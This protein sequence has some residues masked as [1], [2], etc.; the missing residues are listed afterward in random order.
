MFSCVSCSSRVSILFNE[1]FSLEICS[2]LCPQE[3]TVWLSG[4]CVLGVLMG[5]A[6]K[7]REETG[8]WGGKRE[9]LVPEWANETPRRR[10]QMA[11][12]L[13]THSFILN[14]IWGTWEPTCLELHR[15]TELT[16]QLPLDLRLKL[17]LLRSL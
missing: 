6:C 13:E 4:L 2:K 15:F 10:W 12:W 1:V 8:I 16:R 3:A 17:N 7:I 5:H 14:L 11:T 9:S